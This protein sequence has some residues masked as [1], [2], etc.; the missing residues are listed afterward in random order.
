M[1]A[2]LKSALDLYLANRQDLRAKSKYEYHAVITNY[3]ATVLFKPLASITMEDVKRLYDEAKVHSVA[4]ARKLLS[5]AATVTQYAIDWLDLKISNTFR[6]FR[7]VT[8][9]LQPPVR[10]RH[11]DE[12]TLPRFF[13]SVSLL[14]ADAQ[15]YMLLLLYTG[16][17]KEEIG[18]LRWSEIDLLKGVITIPGHRRKNGHEHR[19]VLSENPLALIKRHQTN[20]SKPP[21]DRLFYRAVL[22][23]YESIVALTGIDCR[24][25]DLR[26]TFATIC[27]GLKFPD[28]ATKQLMG[29][30]AS[31]ITA[32]Y[33]YLL[34]TDLREYNR[35]VVERLRQ[36]EPRVRV[37][38]QPTPKPRIVMSSEYAR[39]Y[40]CDDTSEVSHALT[41]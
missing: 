17:R 28:I 15:T 23:C 8:K 25:H 2:T 32:R 41:L 31:D 5:Y 16:C 11:L 36:Y 12:R 3:A 14:P 38:K 1:T 26:R 18:D 13:K 22:T 29:H 4:Q 27:T 34:D 30:K 40:A 24:P 6:R 19:I 21:G 7:K 9:V 20:S 10:K 37:E 35:L 33:V 39:A